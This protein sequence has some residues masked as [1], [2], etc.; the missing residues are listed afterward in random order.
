[1]K[2]LAAFVC[3]CLTACAAL[4]SGP[5]PEVGAIAPDFALQKVDGETVQLSELRGEVVLINFWATWCIP[6]AVEMPTI[7]ARYNQG[8][9]EVLAVNFDESAEEVQ[10]YL[11]ELGLDFPALLDSGGHVQ[12]LYRVR[13]YPSTFFVDREGV[14][15]IFHIGEMSATQLDDY[16]AEL[17]VQP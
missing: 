4:P 2:Q 12:S 17:G 6:C 1:M 16:L 11:D 7:Q 13:G 5:A 9:F 10:A 8:G 14:I 15:R 3:V